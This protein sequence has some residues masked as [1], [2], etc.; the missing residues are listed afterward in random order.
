V[1]GVVGQMVI[2]RDLG[3]LQKKTPI[4]DWHWKM[5]Q[6]NKTRLQ[7]DNIV[8]MRVCHDFPLEN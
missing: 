2:G 5:R 3:Y 1:S 4:Y 6:L 8:T 7:Y